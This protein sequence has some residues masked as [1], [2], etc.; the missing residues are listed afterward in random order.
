MTTKRDYG[1]EISAL[2]KL[3]TDAGGEHIFIGVEHRGPGV[4][5][6]YMFTTGNFDNGPEALGFM[7]AHWQHNG[8]PKLG[9][10]MPFTLQPA[11]GLNRTAKVYAQLMA[12][13]LP[14]FGV[15]YDDP[16]RPNGWAVHFCTSE[17]QARVLVT[18][19]PKDTH[20]EIWRRVGEAWITD[21]E[22][23]ER[24]KPVSRLHGLKL[25]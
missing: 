11:Q 24:W 8:S 9:N 25:D 13:P 23:A 21:G 15:V 18:H 17:R 14:Q 22:A 20:P 5:S 6:I 3:V 2:D 16:N 12:M 7:T 4:P 10:Q 1:A 19:E